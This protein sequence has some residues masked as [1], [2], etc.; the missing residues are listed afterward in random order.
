MFAF[1]FGKIQPL[2]IKLQYIAFNKIT[3]KLIKIICVI[4]KAS[5]SGK[6]ERH[7]LYFL[8]TQNKDILKFS[9]GLYCKYLPIFSAA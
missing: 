9:S 2:K 7:L 1:L 5:S 3:I 6:A 4:E 8:L